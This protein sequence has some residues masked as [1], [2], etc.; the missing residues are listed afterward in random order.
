MSNLLLVEGY[1]DKSL[2]ERICKH[3]NINAK[4]DVATPVDYIPSEH[5]GFNSKRGVIESL[6]YFLPMLEDEDASVKRLALIL[7]ADISGENNG[8]FKCT[9]EQI[10][11]KASRHSYSK[12][13]RYVNGGVEIP[14]SDSQMQ[15]LKI[16]VMPN[17]KDD[18]SI[19]NWIKNKIIEPELELFNH[20]CDVVSK[21]KN[22]KFSV[23]SVIKAEIATWLAWQN[24][25]GRTVGYCFKDGQNLIDIE[26]AEFK[27]FLNWLRMFAG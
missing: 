14:H 22:K 5:G 12:N 10:K 18:G 7:D 27:S 13:H 15:P 11:D 24:Q 16:W 25:P 9:I 3:Y 17:N 4:I 2:L 19:E 23:N 21:I 6:S 8:G 20:A 1:N 26:H